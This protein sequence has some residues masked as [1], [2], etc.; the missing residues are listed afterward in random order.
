MTELFVKVHRASPLVWIAAEVALAAPLGW[1]VAK[2][3]SEPMNR[4]LRGAAPP[5]VE[6]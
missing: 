2:W 3:Y 5:R 1:A 4:R 6:G